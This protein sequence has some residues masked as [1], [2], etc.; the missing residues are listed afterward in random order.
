VLRTYDNDDRVKQVSDTRYEIPSPQGWA[1]TRHES[2]EWRAVAE[3]ENY[4]NP[5]YHAGATAYEAINLIIG[6]PR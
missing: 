5:A 1:V 4:A 6:D 3:N 2:G